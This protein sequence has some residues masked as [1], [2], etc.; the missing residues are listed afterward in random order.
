MNVIDSHLHVWNLARAD[1]PWLGPDLSPINVSLGLDDVHADLRT[2]GVDGVV[3]V[4][5][6]DN[7][8]DTRNMFAVADSAPEVLGVVAWAPLNDPEQTEQHIAVL[9]ADARFV[10]IR[11]LIHDMADRD[12]ISQPGPDAGLGVLATHDVPFD[13]VTSDPAALVHVPTICGRHPRLRIVIDHLA[14]PPVGGSETEL[15]SWRELLAAS[16]QYP[17]VHAKV[18]GLYPPATDRTVWTGSDLRRIIDVALEL[19]G[20]DRLMI[21]SDWPVSVLAGGSGA[22]WSA[23]SRS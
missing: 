3:L 1:Y 16:A 6:A 5:A 18:S 19:F 23:S 10:G 15:Q 11:V 8:D 21:G 9:G 20:P 14:K 12:W 13:Y 17:Q 2:A 4:Q 7:S 22:S